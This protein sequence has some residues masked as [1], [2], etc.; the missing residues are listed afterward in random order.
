MNPDLQNARNLR[1]AS[2]QVER[3]QGRNFNNNHLSPFANNPDADQP[4]IQRQS[5]VIITLFFLLFNYSNSPSPVWRADAQKNQ[6][7]G[8]ARGPQSH[9]Q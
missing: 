1:R 9:G 8:H 3:S 4:R 6:K 2:I 5:S 7:Y